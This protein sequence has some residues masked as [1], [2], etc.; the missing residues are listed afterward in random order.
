MGIRLGSQVKVATLPGRFCVEFKEAGGFSVYRL[1]LIPSL[2]LEA[3][4][5]E[6]VEVKR[7]AG[8][9]VLEFGQ[10]VG[11]RGCAEE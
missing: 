10:G 7:G 1:P 8:E 3:Q 5:L 2:Q 6:F 11:E 4:G 9:D